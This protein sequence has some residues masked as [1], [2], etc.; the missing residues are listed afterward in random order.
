MRPFARFS[1][2]SLMVGIG[3]CVGSPG[4]AE[5]PVEPVGLVEIHALE[6]GTRVRLNVRGS[7]APVVGS[8][9]SQG[10]ET[11]SVEIGDGPGYE[12]SIPVTDVQRVEIWRSHRETVRGLV[13]GAGVGLFA[14]IVASLATTRDDCTTTP[15]TVDCDKYD[16]AMDV[17]S[18]IVFPLVGGL[19]GSLVGSA[20][21][22]G[23]WVPGRLTAGLPA[24]GSEPRAAWELQAEW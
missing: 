22:V 20:V 14:G 11:W 21:E 9:R 1:A 17:A 4:L 12:M 5:A 8:L 10:N 15:S 19:V 7:G 24:P 18:L 23:H 2:L 13:V 6:P 16:S 3:F